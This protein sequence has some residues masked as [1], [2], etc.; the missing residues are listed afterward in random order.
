LANQVTDNR[1]DI[2][3][4]TSATGWEDIGG[5]ALA[6]DTEISYDTFSGSIGGYV[7]TTVD[8][9]FYNNSTTGLFS[10][11]DTAYL[12]VNCGVVSLL[13][14]KANRG[15][16]VRVT[17]ATA[18][19][20]A[21]FNLYGS[22]EWP[23]TFDGGWLQIVIDIDELLANPT[24]T[25]GT[26]PTVGNIQRFG[27]TF[28]TNTVMPRMTD[29]IW[30][31][32][33]RIL[34]SNTPAIIV[35]GRDG[36]TTDWAWD[37]IRSVAAIQLSAVLKPGPAGSFICRGP[38]QFGIS[39]AST[40]AFLDTN[41]TLL[42]DYQEV[43]LD[44]FYN[45]NALGSFDGTTNVT[46]GIKTGTGD[47]ATGAQGGT[48]QAASNGARF[49]MDF[50]DPNLDGINFYGVSIQ[51]GGT[52]LIDDPAN[53]W[54]STSWIDCTS[55]TVD[56]AEVLRCSAINP[57]TADGVAFMKTDDMTDIVHTSFEHSDGHAIELTAATPTNQT[58]KGNLFSGFT[59]TVNSTDAAILNSA[60]G[61]LI[62][63][64][65]SGTNLGLNSYRNTGGGTVDIQASV[66][67]T[68]IALDTANDPI[69]AA[70]VSAYLTADD[71]EV[72]LQ[73]TNASGIATSTFSGTTPADIYY[74][75]RKA[76]P[77]DT[78]YVND[79]GVGTIE[80]G[81]GFSVTRTLRED[82]NNNA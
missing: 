23:T 15:L 7:T 16:G 1:T 11:G 78:K 45:L 46:F 47:D 5:T 74:R 37:S 27:V 20:W 57:N 21:E 50:N 3:D 6:V 24:T 10:S 4:G 60:A 73:D 39:D 17:G 12:L 49:N 62:I 56:N 81:T 2:A 43:M 55:A 38:I 13:H 40:H 59:N 14:T 61:D 72:I 76:S 18:T 77:G 36:G 44:G 34:A 25:N 82:P 67:I 54:I 48:I 79:S 58:N 22:D 35:E 69:N 75:I 66:T 63:G 42:W 28:E 30:V 8:G 53:S 29:N 41:K 64:S 80:S 31:G 19:D 68:W 26:P 51:H 65:T 71:T 70:Q 32:G 52:F 9:T 33:F